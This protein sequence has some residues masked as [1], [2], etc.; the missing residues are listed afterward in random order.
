MLLTSHTHSTHAHHNGYLKS[1]TLF[2]I[3]SSPI[4]TS[5]SF[6]NNHPSIIIHNYIINN[7]MPTKKYNTLISWI[8]IVS[9]CAHTKLLNWRTYLLPYIHIAHTQ[10]C[11][12]VLVL[13]ITSILHFLPLITSLIDSSLHSGMNSKLGDL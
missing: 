5:F 8:L 12:S 4:V 7:Y 1:L 10:T 3:P 11:R 13:S 9:T 6:F 2:I